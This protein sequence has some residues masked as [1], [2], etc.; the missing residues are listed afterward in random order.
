VWL[1]DSEGNRYLDCYNNVPSVGHCH[2]YVVEALARQATLLNTHTRHLHH[3][4]IEYA[5]MLADT[6]PGDPSVCAFVDT[7]T[8][9]NDLA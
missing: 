7:G 6:L 4:V 9:A 1:Y 2:R 8:E 3:N 5:E